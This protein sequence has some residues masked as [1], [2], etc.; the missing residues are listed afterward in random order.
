MIPVYS[1]FKYWQEIKK[2]R[3][4][5]INKKLRNGIIPYCKHVILPGQDPVPFCLVG[6]PAY[7]LLPFL[8]K[9]IWG[10][11]ENERER[12]QCFSHR[13]SRARMVIENS[14]AEKEDLAV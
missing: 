8:I 13:L 5:R 4:S 3:Y 10:G 12:E 2:W 6:E 1:K 11:G 7:P 9:K 14:L